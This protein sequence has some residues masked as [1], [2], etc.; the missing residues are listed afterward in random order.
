ME[1]TAWLPDAAGSNMRKVLL[2]VNMLSG[3]VLGLS[4]FVLFQVCDTLKPD[5]TPMGCHYSGVFI[6]CMGVLVALLSIAV[7]LSRKFIA[8]YAVC[9]AAAAS[10]CWLVPNRIVVVSPCGLCGNPDHAC[11][12]VTMPAVGIIAAIL[13]VSSTALLIMG[14]VTGRS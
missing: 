10:L 7:L 4:P 13:I 3:I 8:S 9:S 11:R 1:H 2:H 6:T 14:L 5:G 12:A